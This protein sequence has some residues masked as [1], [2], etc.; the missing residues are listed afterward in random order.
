MESTAKLLDKA[1]EDLKQLTIEV[2]RDR[3][4]SQV[5][6]TPSFLCAGTLITELDVSDSCWSS[7]YEP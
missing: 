5:S 2:N 7:T 6:F 4:N 3:K 1:V